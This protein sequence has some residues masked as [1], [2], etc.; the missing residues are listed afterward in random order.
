MSG[1][2]PGIV[3]RFETIAETVAGAHAPLRK[4]AEATSQRALWAARMELSMQAITAVC[5]MLMEVDERG[6]PINYDALTGRILIVLPWASTGGK[7]WGLRSS[8]QRVLNAILRD[9]ADQPDALFVFE[10][11]NWF[12]QGFAPL[13]V[14]AYLQNRPIGLAEYRRAWAVCAEKWNRVELRKSTREARQN[15][16]I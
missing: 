9:R 16:A 8:E 3:R 2:I 4:A 14:R 12:V 5:Q 13:R 11:Q 1:L 10:A 15:G 7:V 6:Q